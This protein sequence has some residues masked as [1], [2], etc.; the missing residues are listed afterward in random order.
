M[1]LAAARRDFRSYLAVAGASP[2][3]RAYIVYV[4]E[5]QAGGD[6]RAGLVVVCFCSACVSAARMNFA[7]RSSSR[8]GFRAKAVAL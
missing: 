6:V 5:L 2:V 1:C 3:G 7:C 8:G 4:S